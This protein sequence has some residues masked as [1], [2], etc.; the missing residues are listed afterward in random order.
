M[1]QICIGP[2]VLLLTTKHFIEITNSPQFYRLRGMWLD[3]L[4]IYIQ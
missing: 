1:K 4:V 3:K 2:L